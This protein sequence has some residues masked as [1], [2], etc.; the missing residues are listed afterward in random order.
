MHC[1]EGTIVGILNIHYRVFTLS[2]HC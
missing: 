2:I 1:Q